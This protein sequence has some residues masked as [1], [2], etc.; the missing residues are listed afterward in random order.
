VKLA[1]IW[2]LPPN[3]GLH[4]WNPVKVARILWVNNRISL[5]E[6]FYRW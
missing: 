1:G 4:R 3:F 5:L 2:P 6:I